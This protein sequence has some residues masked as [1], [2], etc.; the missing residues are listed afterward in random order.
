MKTYNIELKFQSNE[1]KKLL[2]DTFEVH[3]NI[4]NYIS[5]YVFKHKKITDSKIIHN[6]TYHKCRKK[7]PTS[8]SQIVIR[9]REDVIST[10]KSIKS[11]Q[12]MLE[13]QA[14]KHNY[15]IRLDK[16]LYTLQKDS[17][18]LTTID[19]RIT[20]KLKLYKKLEEL[21][22]YNTLDPLIFE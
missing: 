4:W 8:P 3:Q 14:I 11:N 22:K 2:L 9:A 12:H 6:Q 5:K 16:R 10:Y 15:S 7:F 20:C 17:I 1:D 19:K 18:K 21:F 13:N